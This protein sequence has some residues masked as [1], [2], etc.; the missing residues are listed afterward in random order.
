MTIVGSMDLN[1]FPSTRN[2]Q[3]PSGVGGWVIVPVIGLFAAPVRA[4]LQLVREIIPAFAPDVWSNLTTPGSG[5]YHPLCAPYYIF[6]V[7]FLAGMI[8][9]PIAALALFFMQKRAFPGLM[10]SILALYAVALSVEMYFVVTISR[11]L[12]GLSQFAFFRDSI[13]GLVRGDVAAAVWIPYFLVSKRVK[14]TFVK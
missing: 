9:L 3:D 8:V 1:P 7:V 14:N 12:L 13:L 4:V 2:D 11:E 10:I 6:E 5:A